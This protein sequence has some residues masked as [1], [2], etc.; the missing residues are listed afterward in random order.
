MYG[1]ERA[2]GMPYV[3]VSAKVGFAT[4][5]LLDVYCNVG[6]PLGCAKND[7]NDGLSVVGDK[8]K[9]V[10]ALGSVGDNEGISEVCITIGT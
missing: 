4:E 3:G 8:G 10:G 6:E 2:T 1:S 5:R 9:L 7:R